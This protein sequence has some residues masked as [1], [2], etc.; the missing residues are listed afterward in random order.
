MSERYE[1]PATE[2]D[3]QKKPAKARS[4]RGFYFAI[5]LALSAFVAILDHVSKK[6]IVHR[7]PTG[8]A[9]TVIPGLLRIT[10]VL[11][12]GA[13]F[14]FL[15]DTA[16]PDLVLKALIFFSLAAVVIVGILLIR[17]CNTITP[18]SVALALI[19]GGAVG[20]LYDRV[21]YHYVIDFIDVHVGAY[22][23]P[24]FNIA[25]SAITIGAVLLMIEIFRPQP[26]S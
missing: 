22:H 14:S 23:W 1:Y 17:S 18:T 9:H 5:L 4:G 11:N 19:L 15:A 8:R 26:E 3:E 25:D 16:S 10:H 6:F 21:V 20:N 7:L 13:A 12:T 24:D 2:F